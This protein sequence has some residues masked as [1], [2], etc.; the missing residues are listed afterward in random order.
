MILADAL[1]K[2]T[3][4]AVLHLCHNEIKELG[5]FVLADM[6]K[7]NKNIREVVLDENPIGQRGGR[8]VLRC[9]RKVNSFGWKRDIS[10]IHCNVYYTDLATEIFGNQPPQN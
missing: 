9:I 10:I 8:A 3:G 5:A 4:L 7:E 6:L 2:N 1:R